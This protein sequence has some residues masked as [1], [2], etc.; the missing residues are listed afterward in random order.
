[1]YSVKGQIEVKERTS[2][3]MSESNSEFFLQFNKK[4]TICPEKDHEGT[5]K[6]YGVR[7]QEGMWMHLCI[8]LNH[9]INTIFKSVTILS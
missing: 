2:E 3:F 6:P 1:V 8:C 4:L 9:Y 5:W 7:I